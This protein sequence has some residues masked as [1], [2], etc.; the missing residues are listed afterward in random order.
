[1]TEKSGWTE[2]ASQRLI[3]HEVEQL[4]GHPLLR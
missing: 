3:L 2:V 1:M 4:T